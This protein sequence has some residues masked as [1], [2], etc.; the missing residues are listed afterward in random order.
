MEKME[1]EKNLGKKIAYLVV[2]AIV[3]IVAV[4]MIYKNNGNN[5]NNDSLNGTNVVTNEDT[6]QEAD[7]QA[8]ITQGPEDETQAGVGEQTDKE[9]QN[10]ESSGVEEDTNAGVQNPE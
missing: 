6:P 7:Q 3:I 2:A 5:N 1:K 4:V 9:T 8:P 10:V